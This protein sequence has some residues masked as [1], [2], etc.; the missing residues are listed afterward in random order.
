MNLDFDSLILRFDKFVR[1]V[2][3]TQENTFA[4]LLK[5]TIKDT[6]E[7]PGEEI[8]RVM[9]GEILSIGT[10]VPVELEHKTLSVHRCVHQAGSS[11]NPLYLLGF[12]SHKH[13]QLLTQYSALP[14]LMRMGVGGKNSKFLIMA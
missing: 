4:T 2:Y 3:K 13:Y 10:S 9:S 1:V 14:L 5:D 11:L 8:Y 12:S 7:Q 6:V